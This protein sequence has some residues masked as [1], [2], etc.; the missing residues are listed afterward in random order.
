VTLDPRPR[1]A[2]YKGD[3]VAAFN[4]EFASV[5][6][7]SDA[8]SAGPTDGTSDGEWW[9]NDQVGYHYIGTQVP[10]ADREIAVYQPSTDTLWE[11]YHLVKYNGQWVATDGGKITHVS[12]NTGYDNPRFPSGKLHGVAAT[13]IPVLATLQRI[14]ELQT[15]HVIKH[16]VS[17]HVPHVPGVFPNGP[18]SFPALASDGDW[19]DSNYS[20][21]G[22]PGIPEGTWFRLPRFFDITSLAGHPYAQM[23]AKAAQ[24]YG[25]IVTDK[26]CWPSR[27]GLDATGQPVKCTSAVTTI[28]ED[29]T[30]TGSNPYP[31]IFGQ[32][33]QE[34]AMDFFPWSQLQVVAPPQ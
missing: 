2:P 32:D 3:D 24:D 16:P 5:P 4:S 31:S 10:W 13:R 33:N 7:P 17:I 26:D 18:F 12:E 25:M 28:A 8:K 22:T 23:V 1:L 30:P 21:D 11:L 27:L 34:T 9:G 14:R 29:W 15:D 20:W 19:N 6:L